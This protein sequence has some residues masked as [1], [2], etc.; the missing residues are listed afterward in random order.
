[1]NFYVE[2]VK[3]YPIYSAMIQF[4]IL[5]TSGDIISKWMQQ[6]EIFLPYK[7]PVILLKMME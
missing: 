7:L 4:S 5:G 2:F 3:A 1:M 6:G